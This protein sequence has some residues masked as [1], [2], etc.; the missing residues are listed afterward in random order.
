MTRGEAR[1]SLAFAV[2][3]LVGGL[4]WLF[5]PYGLVAPAVVVLVVVLFVVDVEEPHRA[6]VVPE[7]PQ[8]R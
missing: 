6:E 2:L 5:G 1:A 7:P 8:R 4:V 3:A